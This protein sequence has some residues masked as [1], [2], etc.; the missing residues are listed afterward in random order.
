MY[1]CFPLITF[2]LVYT[3]WNRKVIMKTRLRFC[4][5]WMPGELWDVVAGGTWLTRFTFRT[6]IMLT[7]LNHQT[8]AQFMDCDIFECVEAFQKTMGLNENKNYSG[9]ALSGRRDIAFNKVMKSRK[10]L[11]CPAP[12]TLIY[13][14]VRFVNK[15]KDNPDPPAATPLHPTITHTTARNKHNMECLC[16]LVFDLGC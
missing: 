5:I 14:I 2:S 7:K 4:K 11:T 16:S 15:I 8:E 6:L 13:C 12:Q 10:P 9:V 1:S 3:M